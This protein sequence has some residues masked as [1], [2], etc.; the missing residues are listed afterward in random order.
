M[1]S[2]RAVA[3]SRACG[4]HGDRTVDGALSRG[5][6][7]RTLLAIRMSVQGCRLEEEPAALE[8]ISLALTGLKTCFMEQP[9]GRIN[10]VLRPLQ[11]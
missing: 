2:S 1:S 3:V 9:K 4:P 6:T 5:G 8:T 7:Q 11:I 10:P